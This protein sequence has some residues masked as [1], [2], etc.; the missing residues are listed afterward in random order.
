MVLR[1]PQ[2][3]RLSTMPRGVVR[4]FI[5]ECLIPRVHVR[6]TSSEVMRCERYEAACKFLERNGLLGIVR[7]HEAQDAGY[8]PVVPCIPFTCHPTRQIHDVPQ[9]ADQ[10][11][12][13]CHHRL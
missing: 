10:K 12:S 13:L 5:R 11:V 1:C 8:V 3:P 2:A 7:G 6:M 9:D 4:T